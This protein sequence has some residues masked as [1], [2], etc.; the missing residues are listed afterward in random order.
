M[1]IV[2]DATVAIP[3]HVEGTHQVLGTFERHPP[4]TL[5]PAKVSHSIVHGQNADAVGGFTKHRHT[6][7]NMMLWRSTSYKFT[8]DPR[9]ASCEQHRGCDFTKCEWLSASRSLSLL[10]AALALTARLLVVVF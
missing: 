6:I 4:E 2:N 7:E 1:L 10:L 9:G 3:V 8:T 5:Q